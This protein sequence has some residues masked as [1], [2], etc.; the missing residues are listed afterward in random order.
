LSPFSF[1]DSLLEGSNPFLEKMRLCFRI[2]S[3]IIKIE[4]KSVLR[5]IELRTRRGDIDS[6]GQAS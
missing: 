2:V 1:N 4:K 3:H 5:G 6:I